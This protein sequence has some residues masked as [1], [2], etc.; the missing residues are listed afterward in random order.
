MNHGGEMRVVKRRSIKTTIIMLR[1]AIQTH[2]EL[3]KK[4]SGEPS[5]PD[6]ERVLEVWCS[7]S[8][9]ISICLRDKTSRNIGKR[10]ETAFELA[11]IFLQPESNEEK[12]ISIICTRK[13]I[14]KILREENTMQ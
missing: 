7:F 3:M 8:N 4:E 1:K 14:I 12:Q 5:S 6:S 13:A 10:I 2:V 11:T 9:A